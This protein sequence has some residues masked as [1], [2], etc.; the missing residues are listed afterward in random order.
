MQGANFAIERT[1]EPTTSAPRRDERNVVSMDWGF[2]GSEAEVEAEE[3]TDA[4]ESGA[5]E[6]EVGEPRSRRRRRRGRGRRDRQE[7]AG[8][9]DGPRGPER[10][11]ASSADRIEADDAEAEIAEPGEAEERAGEAPVIGR[12]P[13]EGEGG[14]R[15][16]RRRRGRRGGRS[17][18]REGP[19]APDGSVIAGSPADPSAQQPEVDLAYRPHAARG[20]VA[21]RRRDAVALEIPDHGVTSQGIAWEIVGAAQEPEPAAT[22]ELAP[23][24]LEAE[25][26]VT[27]PVPPAPAVAEPAPVESAPAHEPSVGNGSM[28]LAETAPKEASLQEPPEPEG[29]PRR[30]WW[31]R[32]FGG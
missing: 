32:R 26:V 20:G 5:G 4:R 31:Q 17:R 19:L 30:G 27:A 2:D 18:H 23:A 6:E 15:S 25:P 14:G 29:P 28:A 3:R 9:P 21:V 16:R 13:E 11:L 10:E 22:E 8:E 7:T 12:R 24:K 1:G